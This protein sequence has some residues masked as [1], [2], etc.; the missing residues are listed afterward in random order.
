M[1]MLMVTLNMT[2]MNEWDVQ[3]NWKDGRENQRNTTAD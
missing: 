2:G 1:M 3:Y